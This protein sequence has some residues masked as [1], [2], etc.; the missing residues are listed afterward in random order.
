[1]DFLKLAADRYSV[2][3][4]KDIPVE[5][6]IINKILKAGHLAPTGC[7]YQPQKILVLN[8]KKSLEKLKSCTKCH[9]NAPLAMLICY[10]KNECWE[11]KYDG[12]LSGQTDASIVTTHMMLQSHELGIGSC[13]I[14]HFDPFAMREAFNVPQN[15]EMAALLVMGYPSEDS[16]PIEMHNTFRPE[17]E[18]VFYESF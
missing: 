16:E 7:N 3:K 10:D 18:I 5:A 12:A 8:T 9:F 1:M 14:M 17:D 4:F 11:R 2:R 6:E 13:W 15:F